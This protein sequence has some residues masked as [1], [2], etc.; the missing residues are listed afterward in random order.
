[1]LAFILTII[2]HLFHPA[3]LL[4][5]IGYFGGTILEHW[6]TLKRKELI[7]STFL[8]LI[9]G[10]I[11]LLIRAETSKYS[12]ADQITGFINSY[13]MIEVHRL[14]SL[15]LFALTIATIA[16][17]NGLNRLYKVII[18]LL[19]SALS[20]LF[21]YNNLPIAIVWI[22]VSF[23]KMIILR[24][25]SI[26]FLIIL[27]APLPLGLPLGSPTY[28]LYVM[29][30]CTLALPF[31]WQTLEDRLKFVNIKTVLPIYIVV[32]LLIILL[33]NG[34]NVPIIY[35]LAK[36]ILAEK[37]KTYQLKAIMDWVLNSKY[38]NYNL[39]L[40]REKY[41]PSENPKESIERA[42]TAPMSQMYV[43]IYMQMIRGAPEEQKASSNIIIVTFG[44]E[45]IQD[46]Y[47]LKS[48]NGKFA[49]E[50]MIFLLSP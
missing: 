17:I 41:N 15:F 3:A 29:M 34:V 22:I 16:S 20:I 1:M 30:A 48:I 38:R 42:N 39:V 46:M 7:L 32:L 10:I 13:N 47:L 33:R 49:G 26:A 12:M 31:G 6:R 2:I 40:Y 36:P 9:S 5:F 37:E 44:N 28:G 43:N 8:L 35:P 27:T 25:W 4:V 50:A 23:L 11:V 21:F 14:I 24:K 18:G 45:K 19:S